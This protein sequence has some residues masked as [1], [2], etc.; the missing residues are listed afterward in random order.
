MSE[1]PP[2]PVVVFV[3]DLQDRRHVSIAK[4][5]I[6]P[7]DFLNLSFLA[8]GVFA[9]KDLKEGRLIPF[10]LSLPYAL[11]RKEAKEIAITINER[12]LLS[13]Q[14]DERRRK[15]SGELPCHS[16]RITNCCLPRLPVRIYA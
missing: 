13:Q 2:S 15:K 7:A 9:P 11:K 5:W 1:V 4:Y 16:L 6:N 3:E 8:T 10:R 12:K 14:K